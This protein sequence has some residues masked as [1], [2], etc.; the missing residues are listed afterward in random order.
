M[1]ISEK[2]ERA[3]NDKLEELVEVRM[4][5]IRGERIGA[6]GAAV[7]EQI[8]RFWIWLAEKKERQSLS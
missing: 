3:I 4:A 7:L 8:T 1:N 6:T 5:S 2:I